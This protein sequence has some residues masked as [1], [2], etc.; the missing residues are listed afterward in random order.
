MSLMRTPLLL[1]AVLTA[2]A[3]TNASAGWLG[4]DC[5]FIA[6]RSARVAASGISH[7]TVVGRAG[8]LKIE[9][10][11]GAGEINASGPACASTKSLLDEVKL[12]ATRSG[13]ELRL[14]VEIPDDLLMQSATLDLTVTIPRGLATT[15]RDGS[16]EATISGT[17][18]LDVTDGSGA[19]T[20][21]DVVGS[22][23]IR[24]GSGSLEVENVAGNV[25][26]TD[27]SGSINIR[28]IGG[29]VDIPSDGS[30]SVD[31][32]DV[33]QNVHVGMKGSGSVGV[34]DVRGDLSVEHARRGA[35]AYDRIGGR[36]SV[37]SR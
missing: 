1:A 9:G 18:D 37:P 6:N 16:G 34:V 19:L 4:N 14:E 21:R 25:A 15:V 3:S 26:V 32:Q 10:R 17:G 24:D 12:T 20:V 2:L 30:G 28:K 35:V 31:I 36:I 5:D 22:A 23:T 11:P 13:S 7:V 27:G 8:S 29:S 33:R